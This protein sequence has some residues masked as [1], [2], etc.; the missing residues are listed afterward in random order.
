[1]KPNCVYDEALASTLDAWKNDEIK[2][3]DKALREA[4]KTAVNPI[5]AGIQ[6][7]LDNLID[8][9]KVEEV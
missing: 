7:M 8:S 3:Y 2:K 9:A 6:P 1:M 4:I 5:S